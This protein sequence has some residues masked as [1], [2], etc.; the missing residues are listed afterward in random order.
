MKKT[1]LLSTA[2]FLAV[3]LVLP[4]VLAQDYTK[5][6]LP[7]GVTTILTKFNYAHPSFSFRFFVHINRKVA[8]WSSLGQ[9]K[10]LKRKSQF[11]EN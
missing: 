8:S 1:Y 5:W 10:V 7:K 3:A 6:N 9:R 11:S 4:D 2:L